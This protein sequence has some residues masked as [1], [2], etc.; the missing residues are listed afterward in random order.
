MFAAVFDHVCD[1]VASF[2]AAV[3][4]FVSPNFRQHAHVGPVSGVLNQ[5][6]DEVVEFV[7]GEFQKVEAESDAFVLCSG[8]VPTLFREHRNAEHR[9]A[10]ID[11]LVLAVG[12]TV[13]YEQ[14][15][16]GMTEDV[17]LW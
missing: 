7:C 10:V 9:Y 16:F 17:V 12:A 13:R 1:P 15:R 2:F 4:R 11:G 6:N 5:F 3:H 8:A 14:L